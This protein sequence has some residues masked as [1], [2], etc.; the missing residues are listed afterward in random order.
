MSLIHYG[1]LSFCEKPS[2]KPTLSEHHPFVSGE[3]SGGEAHIFSVL[4][5][6]LLLSCSL[7]TESPEVSS[8]TAGGFRSVLDISHLLSSSGGETGDREKVSELKM[9]LNQILHSTILHW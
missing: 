4:A 6:V 3:A 5:Q 8:V 2:E 1:C 9:N 7:A